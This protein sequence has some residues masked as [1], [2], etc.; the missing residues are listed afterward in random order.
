M[1]IL[2]DVYNYGYEDELRLMNYVEWDKCNILYSIYILF[3]VSINKGLF[4]EFM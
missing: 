3:V 1:G 2:V 4:I